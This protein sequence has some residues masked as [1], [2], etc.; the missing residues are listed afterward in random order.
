MNKSLSNGKYIIYNPVFKDIGESREK[1]GKQG[2]GYLRQTVH[3]VYIKL[4]SCSIDV[5]IEADYCQISS[6]TM[7]LMRVCQNENTIMII[8]QLE[9]IH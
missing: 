5:L 9:I 8:L 7:C 4:H 6:S 2:G 1:A 3:L